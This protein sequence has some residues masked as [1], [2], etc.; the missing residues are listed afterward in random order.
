MK[1]TWTAP[2]S[3]SPMRMRSGRDG[4]QACHRIQRPEGPDPV[5]LLGAF[6]LNLEALSLFALFVG[7][8]L[9][10]NTAMF[11][12]VTRRRDAGSC[13]PSALPGTGDRRLSR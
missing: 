7:I 1:G 5:G 3:S 6:K 13:S 8:F 10:Y 11:A 9:I 12:V 4:P 2:T